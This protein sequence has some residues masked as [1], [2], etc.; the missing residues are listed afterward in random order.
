MKWYKNLRVSVKLISAFLLIAAVSIIVGVVGYNG[1][2]N[3]DKEVN[4]IGGTILPSVESMLIIDGAQLAIRVEERSLLNDDLVLSE[5]VEIYS[6]IEELK[7]VVDEALAVYEALPRD[8][9]E[10]ISWQN[11]LEKWDSWISDIDAYIE[12]SE[13]RDTYDPSHAR[14]DLLHDELIDLSYGKMFES[15]VE[16]EEII[17]HI[18]DVDNA[19]AEEAIHI[20]DD[21]VANSVLLLIIAV[22]IGF[23]LSIFLAIVISRIISKPVNEILRAANEIAD[24][25]LDI[26]IEVDTKDEIGELGAAFV[27]MTNNMNSVMTN[28][29]SASEQVASGS[30]QLS[31][32]SMSLSQG[33]TEQ[34]SSIEELTASVE[35]IASQTRANAQNA[36]KAKDMASSAYN[37]AE[38]GNSQMSD[39]LAA[40][41]DINESSSNIS[42][43]IKVIDDIAFQTNILALNAA[44]E[45]ARAGQHGKGFAVVAEEVRNLAARSANA[46]QETTAMIEGSINKVEGGTKIA[47]ETAVALNKIVEGVSEVTELVSEIAIASNEQALGVEQV[48]QGLTQIS[49]VVQTTSA[50]AEETAAASEELSGQSDM[51]KTQVST[52]KLKKS[53][54]TFQN[55]DLNPDVL[56]ML[57]KMQS[58]KNTEAKAS[59]VKKISLSDSEFE[60]Y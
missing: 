14:F 27:V 42:K 31:D 46:A 45:A 60:K 58:S 21:T 48:N 53:S 49:D 9:E 11:L 16:S 22:I 34:A 54:G 52:F 40:M 43:I 13:E 30:R 24:G 23:V 50:T 32:S 19:H 8:A 47:N 18:I 28:I 26:D 15:F 3:V 33:A 2:M 56:K 6:N 1:I 12:I 44:V 41:T 25:N 20:A 4:D 57:E 36:E 29:N 55:N 39:M 38:Q 35:E 59:D 10:E 37:Y 17:M 7:E 51:L 5:R